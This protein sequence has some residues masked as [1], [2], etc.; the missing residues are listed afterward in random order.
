MKMR[1]LIPLMLFSLPVVSQQTLVPLTYSRAYNDPAYMVLEADSV[2][3]V[4]EHVATEN[5]LVIFDL[6]IANRSA[7]PLQVDPHQFHYYAGNM[8]FPKLDDEN[9]DIHS[10]SYP[11]SEMPGYMRRALSKNSVEDKYEKQIKQQKTLAIVFGVLTLTAVAA[12]V[13]LDLKDAKKEV[14]TSAD[15]QRALNRDAVVAGTLAST[16]VLIDQVGYTIH[17]AKEELHYLDEEL[18]EP[19]ELTEDAAIRG[20]VYF[21]KIGPYKFYRIV[22]PVGELNYVFDFRKY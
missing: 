19:I 1:F 3:A 13:A 2:T 10:A 6:E 8:P 9:E 22:I 16:D 17:R 7:E 4:L 21:P 18:I 20:K 5:R 12:D 14:F 15:Y 11:Y